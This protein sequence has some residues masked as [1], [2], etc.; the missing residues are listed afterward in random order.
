MHDMPYMDGKTDSRSRFNTNIVDKLTTERSVS[1][2][3][4]VNSK[5][6]LE[7]VSTLIKGMDPA[8]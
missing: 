1:L 5:E 3:S 6:K 8:I 2:L 7:S 4:K